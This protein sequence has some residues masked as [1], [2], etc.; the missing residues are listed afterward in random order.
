M[1]LSVGCPIVVGL[2]PYPLSLVLGGDVDPFLGKHKIRNDK[3]DVILFKYSCLP[4]N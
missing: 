1:I 4:I 2:E 3:Y